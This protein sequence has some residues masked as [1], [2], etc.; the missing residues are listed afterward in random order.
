MKHSQFRANP[1]DRVPNER[2]SCSVTDARCQ[3]STHTCITKSGEGGGRG[4]G[5]SEPCVV[6]I[7]EAFDSRIASLRSR[8]RHLSLSLSL[9]RLWVRVVRV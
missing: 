2:T 6:T 3:A 4:A 8:T 1:S 7:S 9:T 5:G